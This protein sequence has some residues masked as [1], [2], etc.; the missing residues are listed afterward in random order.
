MKKKIKVKRVYD[1]ISGSD[2][3]RILVDRIWPR[4]IK[5]EYLK[6]DSW[7]KEIAPSTELRKW[8][9][10]K[11]EKWEGFRKKYFIELKK[12]KNLCEEL[13]ANGKNNITLLYSA[14][15]KKHNQA[16]ALKEFL[17]KEIL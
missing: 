16:I 15:D 14:K 6:L 11:P 8:F 13:I 4:G 1:E 17:E 9:S 3:T 12:K 2:G 10:H 5:K 7:V